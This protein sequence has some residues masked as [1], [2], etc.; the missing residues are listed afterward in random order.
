LTTPTRT[1]GRTTFDL[2]YAVRLGGLTRDLAVVTERGLDH[3]RVFAVDPSSSD[4]A[5]PLTEV[6]EP[7]PPI[8]FE[9]RAALSRLCSSSLAVAFRTA[10]QC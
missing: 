9:G 7:N 10:V 2:L 1:R 4:A 6:T 3:Q 8:V 5:D